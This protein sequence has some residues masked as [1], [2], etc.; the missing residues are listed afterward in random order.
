[1]SDL[2]GATHARMLQVQAVAWKWGRVSA[3]SLQFPACL[4]INC[5]I[6]TLPLP[7]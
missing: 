2:L 5:R 3:N 4:G 1:M 7:N 6:R